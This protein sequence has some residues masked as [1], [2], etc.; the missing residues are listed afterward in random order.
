MPPILAAQ[1]FTPGVV[2]GAV[3]H[4][5]R[6][7]VSNTLIT[8][9][10]R[11]R[12]T[13]AADHTV[14]G[15]AC[16]LLAFVE[17]GST[18][19]AGPHRQSVRALA[20]TLIERQDARGQFVHNGVVCSRS[21]QIVGALAMLVTYERSQHR[22]YKQQALAACEALLAMKTPEAAAPT[23]EDVALL[24]LM[25]PTLSRLTP[26]EPELTD[27]L[28]AMAKDLA[29]SHTFGKTRRN[30][31]AL[32]FGQLLLGEPHPPELSVARTWP[33]NLPADPLH[34]LF[35]MLAV[36]TD[37]KSLTGQSELI[38]GLLAARATE[39]KSAGMWPAAAGL[40]ETT[41]TAMLAMGIGIAN[42]SPLLLKAK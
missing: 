25:L 5:P 32:H 33:A 41:T 35:A 15:A 23:S 30:D 34:T 18:L 40:D 2:R 16:L 1:E 8:L 3:R 17:N 38:D 28:A 12:G 26:G 14:A 13:A 42:G 10:Q 7:D 36:S 9:D 6:F 31:A 20:K 22:P 4:A 27:R 29:A 39:G 37:V 21:D 24:T 11:A 19:K